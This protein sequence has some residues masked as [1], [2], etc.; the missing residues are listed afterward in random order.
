MFVP[1]ADSDAGPH[2]NPGGNSPADGNTAGQSHTRTH[3][4]T[5]ANAG[6]RAECDHTA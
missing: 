6:P 1:N 3:G 5:D 2:K 4:H